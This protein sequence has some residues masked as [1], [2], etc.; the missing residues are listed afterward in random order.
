MKYWIGLYCV[1]LATVPMAVGAASG[2]DIDGLKVRVYELK[3]KAER[4]ERDYLEAK[5][6]YQAAKMEL[7]DRLEGENRPSSRKIGAKTDD[8]P[9]TVVFNKNR[10][11]N[12]DKILW[13]NKFFKCGNYRDD[14]TCEYVRELTESEMEE[15]GK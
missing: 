11:W 4:A 12:P 5:A 3:L 1:L 6:R 2:D 14:G 9:S 7:E 8:L 10:M 15:I 13:N